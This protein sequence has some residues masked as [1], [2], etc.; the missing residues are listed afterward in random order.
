[1]CSLHTIRYLLS[2]NDSYSP[3]DPAGESSHPW[4]RFSPLS[5][6]NP[7][8]LPQ[9]G[10]AK[11]LSSVLKQWF[12][13]SPRKFYGVCKDK[14]ISILMFWQYCFFSLGWHLYPWS[15]AVVGRTARN[16]HELKQWHQ[17]VLIVTIVFMAMYSQWKIL[18]LWNLKYNLLNS[19]WW[20]GMYT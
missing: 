8:T 12:S 10:G 18:I 4:A 19:E 14:N 5:S 1:M 2:L 7:P 9:P 16:Q 3:S 6:H 20:N 17:N 15:K 13:M 11:C